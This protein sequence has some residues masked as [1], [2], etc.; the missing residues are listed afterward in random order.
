MTIPN[1]K[2]INAVIVVA[3]VAMAAS[4]AA[5]F[6]QVAYPKVVI[7][8]NGDPGV[9]ISGEAV[10]DGVVHRLGPEL[11][12]TVAVSS[13]RISLRVENIGAEGEMR[14]GVSVSGFETDFW[15]VRAKNE[16]RVIQGKIDD[17]IPSLEVERGP[18]PSADAEKDQALPAP[19]KA[20]APSRAQPEPETSSRP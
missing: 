4:A 10:V 3:A 20:D 6:L 16:Y 2:L 5:L 13:N 18:N 12:A 19:L 7:S 15:E 9:K 17:G 1:N 8:I 14:A 11:P